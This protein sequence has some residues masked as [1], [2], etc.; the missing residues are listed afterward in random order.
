M[1]SHTG[2]TFLFFFLHPALTPIDPATTT[3]V[4]II[5]NGRIPILPANGAEDVDGAFIGDVSPYNAKNDQLFLFSQNQSESRT[6]VVMILI[7]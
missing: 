1:P 4:R 7:V 5:I 2:V 3:S 6:F